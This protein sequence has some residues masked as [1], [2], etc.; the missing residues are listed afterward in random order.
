MGT[1]CQG[2]AK[3]DSRVQTPTMPVPVD[4]SAPLPNMLLPACLQKCRPLPLSDLAQACINGTLPVGVKHH[5]TQVQRRCLESCLEDI[6]DLHEEDVPHEQSKQSGPDATLCMRAY[7][8]TY[9]YSQMPV[10]EHTRT[11]KY[12]WTN[13][14]IQ[15]GAVENFRPYLC[16]GAPGAEWAGPAL[17]RGEGVGV[18]GGG[19]G[20]VGAQTL[21]PMVWGTSANSSCQICCILDVAGLGSPELRCERARC[22][23]QCLTTVVT[24]GLHTTRRVLSLKL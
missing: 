21:L 7:G 8:R 20:G 6:W 23:G 1:A 14:H 2:N 19:L 18:G 9:T 10:D 22:L 3:A 11:V 5:S 4:T 16:T 24:V 12:L 13:K 17:C 15:S